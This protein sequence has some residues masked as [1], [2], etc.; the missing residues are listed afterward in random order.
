MESKRVCLHSDKGR[1]PAKKTQSN[2]YKTIH[3]PLAYNQNYKNK[4]MLGVG[5]RTSERKKGEDDAEFSSSS[6][7]NNLKPANTDN[8]SLQGESKTYQFQKQKQKRNIKGETWG[9]TSPTPTEAHAML[10]SAHN[11]SF[12]NRRAAVGN[13]IPSTRSTVTRPAQVKPTKEKDQFFFG[14][15]PVNNLSTGGLPA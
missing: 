10:S 11:P 4:Q 6:R 8:K 14:P 9:G 2:D 15:D 5:K 7:V 13:R 12:G 3:K 1:F